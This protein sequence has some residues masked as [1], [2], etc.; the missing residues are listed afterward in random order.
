[1]VTVTN[2]I[3]VKQEE[4]HVLV[5]RHTNGLVCDIETCVYFR[6]AFYHH[7][8][9][10]QPLVPLEKCLPKFFETHRQSMCR[11]VKNGCYLVH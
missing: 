8:K 6:N 11:D 10:N 5:K 3:E 7:E 2:G 9:S 4:T 1:M